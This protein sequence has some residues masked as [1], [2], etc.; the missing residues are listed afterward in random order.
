MNLLR[1]LP[2]AALL[3]AVLASAPFSTSLRAAEP[4]VSPSTILIGQDIDMSGTIAVRMKPLMQA[5]DAY[6][7]QVNKKGGVHGRKIKIVR[8]D[9]AEHKKARSASNPPTSSTHSSTAPMP[10]TRSTPNQKAAS[11][12]AA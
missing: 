6:F 4:G 5:A 12:T 8:T 1:S 7:E 9:S 3:V 2:R 10:E 11:H